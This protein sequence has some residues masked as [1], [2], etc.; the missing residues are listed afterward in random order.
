MAE[1]TLIRSAAEEAILSR[2]PDFN[3]TQASWGGAP[4]AR[5]RQQ[6]FETLK[7]KGLPTRRVEEWKY[8]DLRALMRDAFPLAVPP[9]AAGKAKAKEAGF[10]L[11]LTKPVD[12]RQLAELVSNSR[13]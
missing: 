12:V 3:A 2:F 13:A 10:N 4:V 6:A 1:L 8:T 11:Q 9:D 7:S 5:Q